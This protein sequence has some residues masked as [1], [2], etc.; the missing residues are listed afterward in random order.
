M[1]HPIL[2]LTGGIA[3]T[4]GALA[5]TMVTAGEWKKNKIL[6]S[7]FGF[8]ALFYYGIGISLFYFLYGK[9]AT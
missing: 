8:M 1:P 2:L 6:S 4:S 7:F 5:M 3:F 9:V